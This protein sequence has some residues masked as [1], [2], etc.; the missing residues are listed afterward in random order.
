MNAALFFHLAGPRDAVFLEREA[1][2]RELV[3][4]VWRAVC[5][6]GARKTAVL[7]AGEDLAR[8]LAAL[9]ETPAP[10][11]AKAPAAGD[12]W[13]PAAWARRALAGTFGPG[14]LLVV[15]PF[16][17]PVSP[18]RL[19]VF[20]EAARGGAFV[21]ALRAPANA[22]PFWAS[23]L[24][25]R[26]RRGRWFRGQ[27]LTSAPQYR[28]KEVWDK[29]CGPDGILGSQWLPTV[30]RADAALTYD[31]GVPGRGEDEDGPV[32]QA[33]CAECEKDEDLP[34]LYALPLF[35][36]S[37]DEPLSFAPDKA[38]GVPD[39]PDGPDGVDGADEGGA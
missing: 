24:S 32:Y 35:E 28:V 18:G 30:C 13:S 4:F 33:L 11:V 5:A 14:P 2:A 17:G 12:P 25:A 16:S 8:R 20:L 6:L 31:P 22:N 1:L 21:S 36:I 15:S 3:R 27:N 10:L 23:A 37:P 26:S 39:G 7:A 38:R 9:G 19:A 34:L 29:R